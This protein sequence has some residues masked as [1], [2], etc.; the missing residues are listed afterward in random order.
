MKELTVVYDGTCA[1]CRWCRDWLAAE[2]VHVPVT[3]RPADDP[4]MR[5]RYGHLPGYGDELFVADHAGDVWIGPDAFVMALWATRR[6]RTMAG[7][8]T[9]PAARRLLRGL[10]SRRHR[11]SR[12]IGPTCDDGTCA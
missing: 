2:P 4:V 3:L 10:S 8:L 12:L 7:H 9:G 11:L 5:T 1:F 6:Y